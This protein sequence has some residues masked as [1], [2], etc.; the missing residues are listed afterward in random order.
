MKPLISY[1]ETDSCIHKTNLKWSQCQVLHYTKDNLQYFLI[2]LF[3]LILL[4]QC[5]INLCLILEQFGAIYLFI[6]YFLINLGN[7]TKILLQTFYNET[8][9]FFNF[10]KT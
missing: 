6:F 5:I 1:K 2:I 3:L 10:I 4:K 9:R 8:D 7:S